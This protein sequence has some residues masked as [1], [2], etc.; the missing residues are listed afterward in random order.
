MGD[1][2]RAYKDKMAGRTR[3]LHKDRVAGRLRMTQVHGLCRLN[4]LR[5]D[6]QFVVRQG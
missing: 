2:E 1:G 3:W 4:L 5:I 6:H